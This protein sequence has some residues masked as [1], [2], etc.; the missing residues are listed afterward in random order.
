MVAWIQTWKNLQNLLGGSI[1]GTGAGGSVRASGGS[2]RGNGGSLRA[3]GGSLRASRGGARA[4]VGADS[5]VADPSV[6]GASQ[7]SS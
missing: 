1:G 7:P 6:G 2:M 5:M 3:T 4:G